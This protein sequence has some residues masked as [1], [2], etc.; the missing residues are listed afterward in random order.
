MTIRALQSEDAQQFQSLRLRGLSECPT[1]FASSYEEEAGMP[2]VEVATRLRGK[3][4]GAI[5]GW[6]A[7]TQ[8]LGIVGVQR[9]RMQKLAHKAYIWGMYVAPEA[10]RGGIGRQ[11]L[12]HALAYAGNDLGVRQVNLR[13]NTRNVAA[14]KLYESLGFSVYGTERGFLS[15]NA[16]LHDEHQLVR[17]LTSASQ[18][19]AADAPQAARRRTQPSGRT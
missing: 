4:D 10:R 5:F 8:L 1:A 3:P 12:T 11:L 17:N 6:F 14:L 16:M 18:L 19:S 7:G 15:V 13:V 2:L 9:E